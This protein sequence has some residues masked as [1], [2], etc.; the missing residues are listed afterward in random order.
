MFFGTVILF[1]HDNHDTCY[2]QNKNDTDH[3]NT[4]QR[5]RL[6]KTLQSNLLHRRLCIF[7]EHDLYRLICHSVNALIADR[8]QSCINII[9]KSQR[10]I[11][12][13]GQRNNCSMTAFQLTHV[14]ICTI[15]VCDNIVSLHVLYCTYC[16]CQC[17]IFFARIRFLIRICYFLTLYRCRF[18]VGL[19]ISHVCCIIFYH[20]FHG[21]KISLGKFNR[22]FI[23]CIFVNS[24]SNINCSGLQRLHQRLRIFITIVCKSQTCILLYKVTDSG[25]QS[26][27]SILI[28]I[29][30]RRH[31][32]KISYSDISHL[33]QIILLCL[34]EIN[35]ILACDRTLTNDI[36]AALSH[37]H[38]GRARRLPSSVPVLRNFI[39]VF[40]TTSDRSFN[41]TLNL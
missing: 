14:I 15:I 19:C 31:I 33:I 9:R 4:D 27:K 29:F 21:T 1:Q 39:K 5:I 26:R 32:C 37:S 13:S 35:F 28:L 8:Y 36:S 11:T 30:K 10:K 6:N 41:Y 20:Y 12:H 40:I 34:R 7:S 18:S 3:S 24:C 17:I 2:D 23:L 38:I 25:S 16:L 22:I